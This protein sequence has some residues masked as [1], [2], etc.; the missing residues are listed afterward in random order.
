MR[1]TIWI[2]GLA[3]GLAISANFFISESL[4]D[5][6]WDKMEIF[7][8]LSMFIAF[9]LGLYL[10]VSKI[11]KENYSSHINFSQA[12]VASF[13]ITL[14]VT[15]V[16]TLMWEI[17]FRS[18]D[19]AFVD[20]YLEHSRSEMVERG[21]DAEQME[22]ALQQQADVMKAYKNET[23]VRV[24]LTMAEIFPIGLLMALLNGFLISYLARKRE[25]LN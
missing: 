5:G 13:Y 10:G 21:V 18:S 24:G 4:F 17:D 3:V 2:T 11:D 25:N 6:D 20:A 15:A 14:V 7:G 19:G 9:G 1:K 22:A 16:Y 23:I 12:F 8:F